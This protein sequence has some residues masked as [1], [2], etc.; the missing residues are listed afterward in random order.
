MSKGKDRLRRQIQQEFK[1]INK[2]IL[3]LA[4]L[5]VSPDHYQQFRKKVLNVTNDVRRN[6]ESDLELNYEV[7]YEP[8][9]ICEDIVVVGTGMVDYKGKGK[10]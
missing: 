5:V 2:H 8:S 9:T 7:E 10:K 6:I 3:D 1:S 4:E